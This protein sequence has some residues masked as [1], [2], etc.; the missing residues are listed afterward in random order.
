MKQLSTVTTSWLEF[1][2]L[3]KRKDWQMTLHKTKK[4]HSQGNGHQTE[5]TAQEWEKIFASYTFNKD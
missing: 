2:E 4:L 1:Q 3:I 5:E